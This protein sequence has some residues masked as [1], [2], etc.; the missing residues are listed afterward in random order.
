M[1]VCWHTADTPTSYVTDLVSAR[2]RDRHVEDEYWRIN[3]EGDEGKILEIF[4]DNPLSVGF[5]LNGSEFVNP[6][7]RQERAR[8]AVFLFF[9][10]THVELFIFAYPF[11]ITWVHLT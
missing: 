1:D 2:G 3:N 10:F 8:N 4:S 6:V 5:S 11:A 7:E 9:F